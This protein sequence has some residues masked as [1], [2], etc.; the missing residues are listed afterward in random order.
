MFVIVVSAVLWLGTSCAAW[1]FDPNQRLVAGPVVKSNSPVAW[2]ASSFAI[3]IDAYATKF[4]AAMMKMSGPAGS[5]FTVSLT[6]SNHGIPDIRRTLATWTMTPTGATP[7]YYYVD[8]ETPILLRAH[9]PYSLVF[10]PNSDDFAG[11]LSWMQY[12]GVSG[13]ASPD[14]GQTWNSLIFPMCVQVDGYAVP[15][16]SCLSAIGFGLA[17]MAALHGRRRRASFSETAARNL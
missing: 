5:G 4:G 9:T 2:A 17:G 12:A 11:G 15:E 7:R 8:A 6:Q 13:W 14:E 3:G 1:L 16:P 10:K